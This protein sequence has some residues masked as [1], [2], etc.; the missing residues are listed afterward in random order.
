[1]WWLRSIPA[2][3]SNMYNFKVKCLKENLGKTVQDIYD[4]HGPDIIE[5][6]VE[7]DDIYFCVTGTS[8]KSNER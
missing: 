6:V 2:K 1:M 3:W 5:V 4:F 7:A 8:N